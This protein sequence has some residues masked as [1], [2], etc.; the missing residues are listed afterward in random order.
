[1]YDEGTR[2][3]RLDFQHLQPPRTPPSPLLRF[4]EVIWCMIGLN[5]VTGTFPG[6]RHILQACRGRGKQ[7]YKRTLSSRSARGEAWGHHVGLCK[8][9]SHCNPA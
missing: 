5:V 1:M 6:R 7:A 4:L 8:N 3:A 9:A 2:A